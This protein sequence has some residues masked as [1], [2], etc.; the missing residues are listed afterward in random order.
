LDSNYSVFGKVR[1]GME[2]VDAIGQV[3]INPTNPQYPNDGKPVQDV[4][5]TKAELVT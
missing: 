1:A 2:V 4:I 3:P 5:L